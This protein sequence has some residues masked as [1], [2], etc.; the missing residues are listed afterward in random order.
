[1]RTMLLA[2]GLIAVTTG[3]AAA[4]PTGRRPAPV[5]PHP[6]D[7]AFARAD[8]NKDG[9]L[10]K[11]ELAREFRGPNAKA[12]VTHSEGSDAAKP[13][14]HA[15]AAHPDHTFLEVYDADHDGRI[16]KAEFERYDQQVRAG[17]QRAKSLQQRMTQHRRR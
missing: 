10:D 5:N 14:V 15:D 16:S 12:V 7:G 13:K 3:P 11:D 17:L 4:F 9:F 6:L 1:M 8:T 2:A